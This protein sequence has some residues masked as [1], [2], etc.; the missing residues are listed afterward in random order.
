MISEEE[1]QKASESISKILDAAQQLIKIAESVADKYG[2]EFS[3]DLAYGMGG[4][5]TPKTEWSES[6]GWQS[7]SSMC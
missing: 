5:Y 2:V 6:G 1:R 4:V 7:S 3:W